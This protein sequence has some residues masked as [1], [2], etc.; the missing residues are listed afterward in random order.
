MRACFGR[1]EYKCMP[2]DILLPHM[3]TT[4][5]V[6][7][8]LILAHLHVRRQHSTRVGKRYGFEFHIASN[9]WARFHKQVIA[10]E[11]R[12]GKSTNLC[13]ARSQAEY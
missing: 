8:R 3:F 13:I 11:H 10:A 1:R 4:T 12:H 2:A 5:L 6:K 7:Q 9:V